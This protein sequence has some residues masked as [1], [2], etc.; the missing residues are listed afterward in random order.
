M[1]LKKKAE[2]EQ[3]RNRFFFGKSMARRYCQKICLLFKKIQ[4]YLPV[5]PWGSIF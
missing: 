4:V 3:G 5:L 2:A 1:S